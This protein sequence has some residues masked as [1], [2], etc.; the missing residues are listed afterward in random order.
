VQPQIETAVGD[1]DGQGEAL[2][3]KG[4]SAFNERR[5]QDAIDATNQALMLPPNPSSPAAQ[6]LIGQ[7]WEAMNQPD[8]ARAEYQLYLKLYPQGEATD[9]ITQRLSAMGVATATA[10]KSDG[11]GLKPDKKRLSATGSVS[12]YYTAARPRPTRSSTS[13]PALTRAP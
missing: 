4:R 13:P 12:Q 6:E 10:V 7:A 11:A 3:A 2:L 5:F 1:V 8:K 9:R